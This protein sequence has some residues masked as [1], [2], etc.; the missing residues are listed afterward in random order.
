LEPSPN[1]GALK[2]PLANN[3]LLSGPPHI[4]AKIGCAGID[5]AFQTCVRALVEPLIAGCAPH[6]IA[7]IDGLRINTRVWIRRFRL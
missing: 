2:Q 5:P 7:K 3:G 6:I 4:I 1:P